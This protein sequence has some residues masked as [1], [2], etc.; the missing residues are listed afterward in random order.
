M[1]YLKRQDDMVIPVT[2]L[3]VMEELYGPPD[4]TVTDEEFYGAG[5][6]ARVIDGKIFL[7]KTDAEKRAER[8]EGVLRE[9]DAV[10]A[11]TVD[12]M[13]N[14]ARW[15]DLP[16][17]ERDAWIRYRRALKD[18]P[19]QEGYPFTVIWPRIPE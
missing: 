7:G 2:D 17:E 11:R 18:I 13:C 9:R 4:M 1:V 10:F 8:E 12:R 16:G 6:I 5:G 15:A 19:E 3:E 14:A